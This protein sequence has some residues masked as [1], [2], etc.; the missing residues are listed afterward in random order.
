MKKIFDSFKYRD[1]FWFRIFG[2]GLS[3]SKGRLL[4]S[5]RYGYTKYL[6]IGNIKISFLNRRSI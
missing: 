2:Y 5:E 6:K 3:F 1:L 4:F